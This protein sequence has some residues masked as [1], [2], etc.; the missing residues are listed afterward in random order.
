MTL[1]SLVSNY[2]SHSKVERDTAA[3]VKAQNPSE[4]YFVLAPITAVV[5]AVVEGQK[6][7]NVVVDTAKKDKVAEAGQKAA[8]EE[9]QSL[10]PVATHLVP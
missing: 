3:G 4:R 5:E 7:R 6:E 10:F 8:I 2:A 9:V 1:K